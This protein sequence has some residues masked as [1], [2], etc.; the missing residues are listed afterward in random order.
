MVKEG[1]TVDAI[2]QDTGIAVDA[3]LWANQIAYPYRLAVGQSLYIPPKGEGTGEEGGRDLYVFV[4]AYPFINS[5]SYGFV[6]VFLWIYRRG[7][8]G[9]SRQ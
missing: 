1:D 6:C 5:L 4:Y 2:A 8:P 7:K 9:A 3:L